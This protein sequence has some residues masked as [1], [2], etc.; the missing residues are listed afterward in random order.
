MNLC[1]LI[2]DTL[3]AHRQP[4]KHHHILMYVQHAV[5]YSNLGHYLKKLKRAGFIE[6]RSASRGGPGW[7]VISE[8]GVGA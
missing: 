8:R 4:M 2:L 3:N 5:N 7:A 6:Y 1:A